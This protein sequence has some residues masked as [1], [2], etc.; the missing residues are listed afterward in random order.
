MNIN[1]IRGSFFILLITLFLGASSVYAG[2]PATFIIEL[3]P[4]TN[5]L[6]FAVEYNL[7]LLN[8]I[9]ALSLY[10]MQSSQSVLPD[11]LISDQRVLSVQTDD[12][13]E[14]FETQRQYIDATGELVAPEHAP[15]LGT[16]R[17][18]IDATGDTD[19]PIMKANRQYIDATG[20]PASVLFYRQWALTKIHLLQAHKTTQ[21]QGITIAIVDTGIDL[22][23]PALAHLLTPGYDF[24]DG[25]TVPD[26]AINLVDDDSDGLVDEGAGHGTHVAGIVALVAPEAQLMP[27]RVLN[28]EGSGYYFDVVAGIVYAVDHGAQVINL[29]LSG[30]EDEALLRK[31]VDY[32]WSSGAIVVAAAGSYQV[33]YPARYAGVIA[34]GA[35]DAQDHVAEFSDFSADEITVFA[36]GVSIYSTFLNGEY[37]WWSGTSMAAPFISGTA[38]LLFA[39]GTCNNACIADTLPKAVHPVVPNWESRGRINAADALKMQ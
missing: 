37:A 33:E 13:L 28:S 31:A 29:S 3:T 17:Q 5:P 18:Y 9:E 6:P 4:N 2:E 8:Q 14:T 27:V 15:M 26:D 10:K 20:N 38:A 16:Q 25:D 11:D 19:A 24:V 21:G 34:V 1:K 36:P 23:H 35:T 30:T 22:D 32:A 7:I 39:E 12:L